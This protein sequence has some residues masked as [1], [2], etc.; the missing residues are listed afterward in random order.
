MERIRDAD[1]ERERM[2]HAEIEK[3]RD[4]EKEKKTRVGGDRKEQREKTVCWG[5]RSPLH[6]S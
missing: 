4:K 3:T 5:N 2:R 6:H 1:V